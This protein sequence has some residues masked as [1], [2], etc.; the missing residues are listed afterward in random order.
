ME[1]YRIDDL[2]DILKIPADRLPIFLDELK[3]AVMEIKP[4]YDSIRDLGILILG[5]GEKPVSLKG[6]TWKDDG[7]PE[8]TITINI[9]SKEKP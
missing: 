3:D 7:N 2:D 9:V 8:R 5:V 4:L 6:F 1:Q